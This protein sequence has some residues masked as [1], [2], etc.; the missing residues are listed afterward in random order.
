[1]LY[2]WPLSVEEEFFTFLRQR[3][4]V[5]LVLLAFYCAQLC[6]FEDYWFVGG[7]GRVWFRRVEEA[8]GGRFGESLD[9]P[10]RVLGM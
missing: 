6:A 4:P 5:A 3:Q 2:L 1:M 10:R 9:W 7:Q 8:L